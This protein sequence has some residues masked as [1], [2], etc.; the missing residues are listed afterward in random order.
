MPASSTKCLA[1]TLAL[2]GVC[3]AFAAPAQ[4]L[5]KLIDKNGKV[6]YSNEEPKDFD[7]KVIRI[8]VDPKANTATLPKYQPAA[9]A[10]R[11]S[12]DTRALQEKV[13]ERRAALEKAKNNPGDDDVQWVG[14]AGGGTRA[15]PTEAYKHRLAELERSLKEAED[16]LHATQKNGR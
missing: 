1:L 16:E 5:Y 13:A 6:T 12:G 3:L 15:V 4:T 11:A 14:N 10:S 7:G 9:P 2:A 8:E